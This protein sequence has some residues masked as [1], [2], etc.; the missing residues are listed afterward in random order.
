[1]IFTLKNYKSLRPDS[2]IMPDLTKKKP[3]APMAKIWATAIVD[4]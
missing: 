1:M 3:N 4:D 2:W